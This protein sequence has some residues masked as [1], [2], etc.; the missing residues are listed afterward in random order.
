MGGRYLTT[1]FYEEC[2]KDFFENTST[3]LAESSRS[4]AFSLGSI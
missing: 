4:K 2:P 3:E 1:P